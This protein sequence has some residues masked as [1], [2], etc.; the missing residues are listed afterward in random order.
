MNKLNSD[1][2]WAVLCDFDGTI[3]RADVTD[4]LLRTFARPGWGEIEAQWEAGEIG[5]HECMTQQIALLD[6]SQ[7]EFQDALIGIEIDPTFSAFVEVVRANDMPVEILSDGITQ[8]IQA[9][10]TRER[11][12]GIDVYANDLVCIGARQWRLDT[13][14]RHPG[15]ARS[16]AHCKCVQRSRYRQPVLYVGD[17]ASDFCVAARA[18]FVLAKGRLADYCALNG[19][20]HRAI[21]DFNDA[22][23]FM[24]QPSVLKREFEPLLMVSTL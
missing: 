4:H 17:G 22:L 14:Y 6:M 24:T 16:S 13:P 3:S 8:A 11:I 19:I 2:G 5:S 9:I 15:C 18:D 7:A 21:T 12:K 23:L 1:M 10:L 20:P